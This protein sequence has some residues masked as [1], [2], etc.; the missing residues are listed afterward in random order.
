MFINHGYH[1]EHIKNGNNMIP[2]NDEGYSNVKI[3]VVT[4]TTYRDLKKV[5][6]LKCEFKMPGCRESVWCSV[7]P[8]GGCTFQS[9]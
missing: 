3:K 9:L 4:V 2:G 7:H 5:L 8:F 6:M 1:R